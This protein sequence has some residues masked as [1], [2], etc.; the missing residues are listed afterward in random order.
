MKCKDIQELLCSDFLDKELSDE[1]QKKVRAHIDACSACQQF[2]EMVSA[3]AVQPLQGSAEVT[4]PPYMLKRIKNAIEQNRK[5]ALL[6]VVHAIY[7]RIIELLTI[8]RPVL[9]VATTIVAVV[10]VTVAVY[11]PTINTYNA[12]TSVGTQMINLVSFN[13]EEMESEQ[14][15]FNSIIEA[16]FL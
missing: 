3:A 10:I 15:E 8:P 14:V 6:S 11:M 1:Q 2:E 12:D 7:E 16:Y 4:P 5:P 9:V 13:G